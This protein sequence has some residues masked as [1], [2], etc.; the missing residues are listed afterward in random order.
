MI[1]ATPLVPLKDF[2]QFY[3]LN[4]VFL[5]DESR[6][7][8][9]TIKDR[10]SEFIIKEALRLKVDK[11]ALITS[12]NSGFSLAQFAKDT[13]IKIVCIVDQNLKPE[14]KKR[15]SSIAY[16]VL[17]INLWSRFLRPEEVISF[18]RE[19]EDEVIWEVTNG[20][21]EGY[22]KMIAELAIEKPDYIVTPVGSGGIYIGLLQGVEKWNLKTKIIGIGVQE[23]IHSFAEMLST[24]WS[25]YAKA[26]ATYDAL[27]HTIYRLTEREV[28]STFRKFQNY[29]SCDPSSAVVFSVIQKYPFKP[30]EKIIF[31]NSGKSF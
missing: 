16:Q 29:A 7:P 3:H 9:G 5:K 14:L 28:K 20:Y 1:E 30:S 18:A 31:I 10:R 2:K 25:P 26:L 4:H 17:E 15:L 21:E 11:L 19:A 24:P 27:G 22:E 13:P 23:T 12:G 8:F 6:N